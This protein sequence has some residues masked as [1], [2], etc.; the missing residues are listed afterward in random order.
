LAYGD[1]IPSPWADQVLVIKELVGIVAAITPWDFPSSI[2]ARRKLR[3][4]LADGCAK[5]IQPAL[6]TPLTAVPGRA[7]ARRRVT[8]D[9]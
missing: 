4:A 5:V 1:V 9:G 7:F 3:P 2:I 8:S 6:Q